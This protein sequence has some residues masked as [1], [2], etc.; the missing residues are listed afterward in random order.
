[1]AITTR[2]KLN[3]FNEIE[4]NHLFKGSVV[5]VDQGIVS[6]VRFFIALLLARYVT[7]AEYGGFVLAYGILIFMS[8]IQMSLVLMPM[9]VFGPSLSGDEQKK[10]YGSLIKLQAIL[11]ALIAIFLILTSGFWSF[12]F[13]N[14]ELDSIFMA[15]GFSIF[16]VLMQEF[17][18][19]LL[20]NN[21]QVRRAILNDTI[22]YFGQI[23]GVFILIG[24]GTIS[25]TTVFWVISIFSAI[26]AFFG[27]YQCRPYLYIRASDFKEIFK[28]QWVYGKWL[29]ASMA[30]QWISGQIFIYISASLLSLSAAGV[31]GACRI[32][33]GI[34]NVA[35]TGLRN[36]ILPYGAMKYSQDGLLFL[37]A[38]LKKIYVI[39]SFAVLLYGLLI[40]LFSS[41]ILQFL[42]RGQYRGF[43]YVVILFAIQSVMSFYTFPPETGLLIIKRTEGI[44]KSNLISSIT[45]FLIALPLIQFFG[46][47]G[48][49]IGIIAT[50]LSL[51]ILLT[52]NYKINT[53]HIF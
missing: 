12:W 10:Y 31:L 27:F 39:G 13:K 50:Q 36:F 23:V 44:F 45:S 46:I 53:I 49:L 24:K 48:A 4:T 28:K 9:T 15:M 8:Y 37:K 17:F 30:F 35:V 2:V 41:N 34:I 1:M 52:K 18:R 33:F 6:G 7:P 3:I 29:L 14:E 22:C 11:A 19:K 25:P 32:L 20:Y 42:Y 21:L 16:S 5:I 51:V 26:S 40:S 38:F 47:T 43:E